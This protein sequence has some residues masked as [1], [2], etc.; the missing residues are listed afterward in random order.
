LKLLITGGTG[1]LAGRLAQYFS[2]NRGV[3]VLLGTRSAT[4][5]NSCSINKTQFVHTNWDSREQLEGVCQ[6]FDMIIHLAGMSAGDCAKASITE[7]EED[8]CGT[9]LLLRAAISQGVKRFVYFSTAHVYGPVMSGTITESSPTEN[10]HPYAKNHLFKEQLVLKAHALGEIEGVV[11][12][13]SNA[14]GA[15]V[16]AKT[17]CWML[18]ANDLCMQV[19]NTETMILNSTGQQ[20]R[21]FITISDCC[22]AVEHILMLPKKELENSVFNL[23][24]M[25]NPTVLEMTNHIANR[26]FLLTGTKPNVS[27][28]ESSTEYFPKYNLSIEKLIKSGYALGSSNKINEEIDGLILFCMEHK[29]LN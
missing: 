20:S 22:F 27:H 6:G 2:E 28:K 24:G 7:L 25:W 9:S 3:K 5:E 26:F 10:Q 11:V 8:V 29:V 21:N 18:L 1:Y 13:L 16:D 23:G 19:V 4:A 14:F 17:N 15:P 12:R